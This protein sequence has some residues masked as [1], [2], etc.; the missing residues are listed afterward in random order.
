M[1]IIANNIASN[2][3]G[4]KIYKLFLDDE[5]LLMDEGIYVLDANNSQNL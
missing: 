1:Y 3:H 5:T 4:L 2:F